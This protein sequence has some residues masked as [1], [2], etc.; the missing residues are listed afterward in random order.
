M[1]LS[2]TV[3]CALYDRNAALAD[4]PVGMMEAGRGRAFRACLY[5]AE[6]SLGC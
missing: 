6:R 1:H 5:G 2:L 4:A 3:A